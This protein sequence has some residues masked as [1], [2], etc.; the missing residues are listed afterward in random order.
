MEVTVKDKKGWIEKFNRENFRWWKMQMEYCLYQ[1]D[2]YLP[3]NGVKAREHER[4]RAKVVGQESLGTNYVK[5]E[6]CTGFFYVIWFDLSSSFQCQFDWLNRADIE[7]SV[8]AILCWYGLCDLLSSIL[9]MHCTS[10]YRWLCSNDLNIRDISGY[11]Q[12]TTWRAYRMDRSEL[13]HVMIYGLAV[14]KQ[15]CWSFQLGSSRLYGF[16]EI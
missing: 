12:S 10:I 8:E 1:D 9:V 11:F 6:L 4:W 2:L 5:S 13:S 7:G 3:L 15:I 14:S 16:G